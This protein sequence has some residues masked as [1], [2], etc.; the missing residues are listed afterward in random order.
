MQ[1]ACLLAQYKQS[2]AKQLK[3]KHDWLRGFIEFHGHHFYCPACKP[4]A[5]SGIS[6][7]G[8]SSS[9]KHLSDLHSKVAEIA[10]QLSALQNTMSS[11]VSAH[12]M[13]EGNPQPDVGTSMASKAHGVPKLT[14]SQAVS[15]NI[16]DMVKSAV[17]DTLR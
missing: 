10:Q 6:P 2:G 1:I 16:S 13:G 8:I 5:A 14:F 4:Q 15:A 3:N 11:L 17:T 12:V 7:S 9:P